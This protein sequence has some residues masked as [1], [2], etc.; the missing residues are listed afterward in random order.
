MK[1]IQLT[2]GKVALVDD[3]DF[4][5]LSQWK[6]HLMKVKTITYAVR[7]KKDYSTGHEKVWFMHRE[8][9]G[10][11]T[12]KE[13]PVVVDHKDRNGLNNQKN[14]L[15]LATS[16][17]NNANS[18]KNRGKSTYKGVSKIGSRG[19]WVAQLVRDGIKHFLG[20][21]AEE[22]EAAIAYDNAARKYFGEFA[23]LNFPDENRLPTG[24]LVGQRFKT[25]LPQSGFRGVYTCG[26]KW[27]SYM[28]Y[29]GK[30]IYMGVF[31]IKE[32]AARAYDAKA[33]E[34]YGKDAVLN[35]PE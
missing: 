26:K 30:F 1:E 13:N 10:L 14:N 17:D 27:T 21:Y 28:E 33:L 16:S 15:R 6:W 12:Y 20:G 3:D 4:D 32:E 25:K 31:E 8:I 22:K 7:S 18:Y 24:K 11:K 29:K 35:F 19:Y 5:F 23:H 34:L 9:L 2:Q